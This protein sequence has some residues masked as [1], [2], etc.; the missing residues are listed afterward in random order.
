[1]EKSV[2]AA[3][4]VIGPIGNAFPIQQENPMKGLISFAN[5][6][7]Y[8]TGYVT[9]QNRPGMLV[10]MHML[11]DYKTRVTGDYEIL[12][13][14]LEVINRDADLL[15]KMNRDADAATVAQGKSYNPEARFP[16]VLTPAE[17]SHP[18]LYRGYKVNMSKSD[19]SGGTRVEYTHE[20]LNIT[21]PRFDTLRVAH[22]IAPPMAYIVPAEWTSLIDVLQAHGLKLLRTSGPWTTTVQTYRCEPPT[23]QAH[24]FEGRQVLAGAGE[25]SAKP[26][27][28]SCRVVEE[29]LAFPRGSVIVPLDQRAA[30]VAIHFLEPEGPDSAVAWGFLNAIFEQ[31]EYGE[32]YVLEKLARDMLEKDPQLKQDFEKRLANDK[33]FAASSAARLNF[34]YQHSPWWDS[35]LGLYPVGRLTSLKGV[36]AQ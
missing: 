29:Q 36:P 17:T 12:R 14:L 27:L 32:A 30:K 24:P 35:H 11:K 16:L 1:L 23:W 21:V 31:K 9:L 26:A 20:P 15:V 22:A 10:E 28:L 25:F 34:F 5:S 4:H 18:F 2:T 3:G 6:P 33:D 8:S 19:I 7:R 13:A